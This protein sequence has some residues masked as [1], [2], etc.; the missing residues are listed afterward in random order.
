MKNCATQ[1][2]IYRE[3]SSA[4]ID[5]VPS[6]S[7]FL[8]TSA[9]QATYATQQQLNEATQHLT[10]CTT[11]GLLY[12]FSNSTCVYPAPNLSTYMTVSSADA[13][14][15][16]KSQV[17]QL[18]VT[19]A[20]CAD[21]GLIYSSNIDDCMA[22]TPNEALY[23]TITNAEATYATQASIDA[24]QA[25][26]FGCAANGLVSDSLETCADPQPDANTYAT[27]AALGAVESALDETENAII[28][29]GQQLG[30]G[31]HSFCQL[32]PVGTFLSKQCTAV[33]QSEC[34][35][36][37]DKTYSH[38]GFATACSPCY[39][40]SQRC[41]D[42]TCAADGTAVE[43]LSCDLTTY[44]STAYILSNGAC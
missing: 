44:G 21:L 20:N 19:Q 31:N 30:D 18:N 16:L 41:T 39:D 8:T 42:A 5:P 26:M 28:A 14:H 36:C 17:T 4:C 12:S 1:G 32:C 33:G 22:P 24:F 3:T 6:V 11:Q 13:I 35:P 10:D 38:G 43:C 25:Q 2:L 29:I 9:A 27:T 37:P 34:T 15:A 23:L 40:L 7:L